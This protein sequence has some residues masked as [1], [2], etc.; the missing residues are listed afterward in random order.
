MDFAAARKV[1]VDSQVR[2][3]DVTDRE[4]QAALLAVP[5][6][7]FL[8]QERA[9]SAYAEIEPEIA[10]GRRLMLARDLSKLL[11]ALDAQ[12]G[13]T[14]LALAAPYAAA[15]LAELG[16]S[17]TA[18]ESDAAVFEVAGAA[19]G[20]AG[21]QTVVAP[22]T[23]PAGGGYDIIICEGAVPGR[24]EAWLKVLNTGGR[25]AVVE[26]TGPV[27]KAVLYVRGEQGVSRR[28]LFNAAPPML[29]ELSPDPIFAL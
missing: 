4:L 23:T 26:R 16:L 13:E 20:E 2:V 8:P 11:M 10:G 15:V 25:M 27:G 3:N 22:L 6:E 7:R 21:V 1:M 18:Q 29:A 9:W 5:R 19:L 24:P 17:V 28:E 14:A 12:H